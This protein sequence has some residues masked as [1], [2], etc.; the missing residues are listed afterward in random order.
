M[1]SSIFQPRFGENKYPIG[2]F[3]VERSRALGISRSD[4]VHRLGYRDISSGHKALNAVLLTGIAGANIAKHLAEA[5]EVD[6]TLV[7]SVID[8]TTSQRHDEAGARRVESE[9]AYCNSFRPHLQVQTERV[10]PSPIFV[11]A[12]LTVTRLRIVRLPDLA[13]TANDEARD[14]IIKPIIINHWR[15]NGGRVPAFGGITGYVLV[16]VA[17]YGSFDFGL[18]YSITGNRNGAI[19]KVERLG[20]ATLGTRRGDTRLTGLLKD[21]PIQVIRAGE[22]K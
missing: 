12:L 5:L 20:E 8:A 7:E 9:R 2:R 19:Q 17:G 18:P 14:R 6:D 1:G 3:I 10:V 22:D 16:S 21:S 11:A 13:L 15:K 4:L